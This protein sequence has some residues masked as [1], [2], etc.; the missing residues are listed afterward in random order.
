MPRLEEVGYYMQGLWLLLV[1]KA[2]GFQYLDF[3]ERGFWRSW[4]AIL[5]CLPPTLLS[6]ASFR[7]YFLTQMPQGTPAG[8]VFF[9]KLAIVEAANWL[10]PLL[11]VLVLA[12][13]AGFASVALP[14][15][16]AFNWL[17][18]PLQWAY[19][20]VSLLQIWAPAE[21]SAALLYLFTL[22]TYVFITYRIAVAMLSGQKFPAL[23]LV[24]VV[25]SVPLMVQSQ[26]LTALGLVDL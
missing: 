24:M 5:F 1:G 11:V 9:A 4:W 13:I 10:I 14:M 19:V 25:F 7:I 26:L 22:G 21:T 20:P 3:S 23:V 18:V 8:P 16:I 6:W 2:E 15:I 17:S 12:R